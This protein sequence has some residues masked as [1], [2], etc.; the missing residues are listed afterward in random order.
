MFRECNWDSRFSHINS[1]AT[2]EVSPVHHNKPS[3]NVTAFMVPKV[4]TE[5][6]ASPVKLQ[7]DWTHLKDHP[8]ADPN[9]GHPRRIDVILGVEFTHNCIRHGRRIGPSDLQLQS[10]SLQ[11]GTRLYKGTSSRSRHPPTNSLASSNFR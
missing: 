4:T 9:F 2:F 10:K 3:V 6:P 5:L 11:L 7:P 1:E 8:L